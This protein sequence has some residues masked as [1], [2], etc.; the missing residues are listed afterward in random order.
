MNRFIKNEGIT[1]SGV[2]MIHTPILL[3]TLRDDETIKYYSTYFLA[4]STLKDVAREIISISKITP[5]NLSR[6][7]GVCSDREDDLNYDIDYLIILIKEYL[8]YE[9]ALDNWVALQIA[10]NTGLYETIVVHAKRV[11]DFII[12]KCNNTL[13]N[14]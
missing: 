11:Y 5:D 4:L 9:Y 2:E 1:P 10:D 12:N 8:W 3:E 7:E 6:L 14:R 13:I